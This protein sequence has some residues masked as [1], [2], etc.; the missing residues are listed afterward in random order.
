[1]HLK[2]NRASANIPLKQLTVA[3]PTATS[4]TNR[5]R[6][7]H[8]CIVVRR[9]A[10]AAAGSK[11]AF[12]RR[13]CGRSVHTSPLTKEK[14]RESRS[15]ARVDGTSRKDTG[16]RQCRLESLREEGRAPDSP[17][18]PD[19]PYELSG[20]VHHPVRS[21]PEGPSPAAVD[22]VGFST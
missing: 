14:P 19:F 13:I 4:K 22:A 12:Q 2:R 7:R 17:P 1:M 20:S 3:L 11:T 10:T 6:T 9:I 16:D 15:V 8:R 5:N 21:Q 18:V